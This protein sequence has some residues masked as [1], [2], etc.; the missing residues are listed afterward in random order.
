MDQPQIALLDQ[1]QKRQ[2]T[3]IVVLGNIHNQAHVMPDHA[4]PRGKIPLPDA[5]RVPDFFLHGRQRALPDLVE[6]E[7]GDIAQ[8]IGTEI[9]RHGRFI[10]RRGFFDLLIQGKLGF[11]VHE[12]RS[13]R[14]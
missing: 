8:D 7:L 14:Y 5:S 11:F 10:N 3:A 6:V 9:I 13:G 2:A 12:A 1:V 4:L